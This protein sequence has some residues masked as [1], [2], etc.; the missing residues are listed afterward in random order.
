MGTKMNSDAY[1]R[2][3]SEDLEWLNKQTRSLERE[4]IKQILEDS[5]KI[6]YPHLDITPELPCC[7]PLDEGSLFL[8]MSCPKCDKPF[9]QFIN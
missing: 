3:I 1:I 9:R 6:Y 2:L 8:G 5:V 7:K 4:H